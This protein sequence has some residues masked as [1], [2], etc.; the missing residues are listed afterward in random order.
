[1]S[2]P[3]RSD[4]NGLMVTAAATVVG[5]FF[6]SDDDGVDD[7]L[8]HDGVDDAGDEEALPPGP[9]TL[10]LLLLLLALRSRG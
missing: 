9:L 6:S 3:M 1:M 5:T 7:R 4:V 2:V 8:G 10:L